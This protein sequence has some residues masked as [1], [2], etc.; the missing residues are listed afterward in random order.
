M[1]TAKPLRS[2]SSGER[3]LSLP[4]PRRE[5]LTPSL[6]HRW[7]RC[8]VTCQSQAAQGRIRALPPIL[9]ATAERRSPI[10]RVAARNSTPAG[11]E[12]GAPGQCPNAPAAQPTVRQLLECARDR[13]AF[14]G[15]RGKPCPHRLDFGR[16]LRFPFCK[17]NWQTGGKVIRRK[18][19]LPRGCGGT[20]P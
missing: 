11:P 17:V 9:T 1:N 2:V 3:L 10:R 7:F 13:A 18:C 8:Q 16:Q 19:L 6:L 4:A 5:L 15:E 12:A 20:S 14:I